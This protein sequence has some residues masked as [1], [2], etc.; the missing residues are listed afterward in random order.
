M[1]E[2]RAAANPTAPAAEPERPPEVPTERE[3]VPGADIKNP[4]A[5]SA[6][7]KPPIPRKPVRIEDATKAELIDGFKEMFASDEEETNILFQDGARAPSK[8]ARMIQRMVE[9][10]MIDE[11]LTDFEPFANEVLRLWGDAP[12]RDR[13]TRALRDW[14]EAGRRAKVAPRMST[15]AEIDACYEQ[16]E[17]EAPSELAEPGE[18]DVGR[19]EPGVGEGAPDEREV[20]GVRG[21]RVT[22]DDRDVQ[23]RDER[24]DRPERPSRREGDR[25]RADEGGGRT[26]SQNA[27]RELKKVRHPPTKRRLR[28]WV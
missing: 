19:G 28:Q 23:G 16:Y 14:Y 24:D 3:P 5:A 6:A 1:G 27:R 12:N 21:E 4:T 8:M 9:T 25:D 13:V 10:L 18:R 15:P 2:R 20:R 22:E 11:G 7:S 17:Q 26:L